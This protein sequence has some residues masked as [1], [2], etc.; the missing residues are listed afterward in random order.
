MANERNLKPGSFHQWIGWT[1]LLILLDQ[2]SKALIRTILLPGSRLPLLDGIVFITF[3][4]NYRGVSWFVPDL[5]EWM[6]LLFLMVRVL[7]LVLAF[8][9]YDFY[10][11]YYRTSTWAWIA[12]VAV[13]AGIAGNLLDGAFTPYTTDFIQ[14]F[15]SPSANFA[16]LLSLAG[17]C[18][19]SVE[20]GLQWK[21]IKSNWRGIR[22]FLAQRAQ[23]RRAF[24]GYLKG[25]FIRK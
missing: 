8:P 18:A 13:S 1:C 15:K 25:Y 23:V 21:Q 10:S 5:P 20:F 6:L 12:L 14:L 2:S 11:Q 17:I 7:V 24:Y 4:P 3:T 16:D 19:L 22:H 9:I